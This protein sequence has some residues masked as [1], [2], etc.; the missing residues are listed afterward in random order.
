MSNSRNLGALFVST[1]SLLM[2]THQAVAQ[3][4]APDLWHTDNEWAEEPPGREWGATSAVYPDI[5][6]VHIWVG[7][8][9]GA[10]GNCLDTPELDPVLKFNADGEVVQSFGRGLIVWPHG[11]HVDPQGNIWVADARGDDMRMK[12]HQVHKFSPDGELLLSLGTAG[13]AGEGRNVF[14]Q[15]CDVLVAPNGD[16][17]VAD[18]HSA[19]G[20]NRIVKY[21]S[22]GEYQMEW[23]ETG[24]NPGQFR[25]P[26]GLAMDSEGLL[27]V[28][29]R[30]N[31]R[32]QVFDQDGNFVT[33]Y[34]QFGRPSGVFIDKNDHIY[35]ADSESREGSNPGYRRGI[36][37]A[38]IEG[39]A[40]VYGFIDDPLEVPAGTSAAEGVAVD[41]AGNIY[42]A[43]VGPRQLVKYTRR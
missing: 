35:V 10:N 9:C 26:H 8:R 20:N 22:N 23:G 15:P 29:D 4:H 37:V 34:Y 14:D 5:D 31:R 32:V 43:E 30:S 27:Y 3:N 42:G 11:I 19:E 7:E 21:N 40:F 18:G 38:E 2:F 17:F 13:V 24:S 25:T 39:G 6:G 36:R 33:D 28:G 1:L 41:D 12:G 16:I